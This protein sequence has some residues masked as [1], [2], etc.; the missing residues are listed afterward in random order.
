LIYIYKL[1][2]L[3]ISIKKESH[4]SKQSQND[5]KEIPK[6]MNQISRLKQN[7]IKDAIPVIK[8]PK[9]QASSRFHV[10]GQIE[11]EKLVKFKGI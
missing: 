7:S 8:A 10:T 11:L 1:I 6:V 3:Y 5:A 9:R 2:K 4:E